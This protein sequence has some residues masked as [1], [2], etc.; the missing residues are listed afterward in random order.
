[1]ASYIDQYCEPLA[2]TVAAQLPNTLYAEQCL[3]IPLYREKEDFCQRLIKSD[4]LNK[5]TLIIL[6]IN[7]PQSDS[8]TQ[9]NRALWQKLSPIGTT[10]QQGAGYQ[11]QSLDQ[12]SLLLLNCFDENSRL[13][14]KQGVGLARKIGC[15]LA[16]LLQQGQQLN[17]TWVHT[18]DADTHLP[19]NYFSASPTDNRN[20]AAVYDFRHIG[21]DK[22][23]TQATRLYEK[24]LYHH[25]D[26]LTKAGSPYAFH[27]LGSCMAI[28]MHYYVKARGFPK[29][30]G[31]EDFYLLN[32][33]AKLAPIYSIHDCTLEIE[34]RQSDRIP[35]GTG[36]AVAKIIHLAQPEHEYLWYNPEIYGQLRFLLKHFEQIFQQQENTEQWLHTLT[37][38]TQRALAALDINKLFSHIRKQSH[39]SEQCITHCHHWFDAFKTLKFIHFL[40]ADF[41]RVPL[42]DCLLSPL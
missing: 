2:K 9:A 6:V 33:L 24:A 30:A 27:T 42:R 16:C 8:D 22:Q 40:E 34:A 28:N 38:P 14:D 36:P 29:R 26:Q 23:I 11:L 19:Q 7:Q 25:V 18:S 20:S 37:E 13:P 10:T 15:D 12:H 4:V 41:P 31:G 32:K 35:F 39:T 5:P 1:M 3:V 17:C 21:E